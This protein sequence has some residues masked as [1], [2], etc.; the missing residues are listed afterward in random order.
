M[1][2]TGSHHRTIKL[3]LS[4]KTLSY[5]RG[6]QKVHEKAYFGAKAW[7]CKGKH[8]DASG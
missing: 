8:G 1:A 5:T 7:T 6:L 3:G 2:Q 4:G